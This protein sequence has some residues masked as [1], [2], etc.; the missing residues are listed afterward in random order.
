MYIVN[1][2]LDIELAVGDILIPN[3]E[4]AGITNGVKSIGAQ[5]AL[6]EKSYHRAPVGI[7]VDFFDTGDVFAAQKNAN[8]L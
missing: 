1:H 7:L 3:R 2:Y 8:G 6:C 4:A 5:V